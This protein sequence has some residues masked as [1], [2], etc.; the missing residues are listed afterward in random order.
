MEKDKIKVKKDS[1]EFVDRTM[2]EVQA[3]DAGL[4]MTI[5]REQYDEYY[6]QQPNYKPHQKQRHEAINKYISC[7]DN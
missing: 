2:L 1:M 7:I 3:F 6:S 5:P 4:S